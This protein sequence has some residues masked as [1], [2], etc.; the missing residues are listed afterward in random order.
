MVPHFAITGV[1]GFVAPRHLDAIDHVGGLLVA[2]LDPHDAVGILDQYNPNTD[3]F[4]EPERFERHLLKLQ[5]EGNGINWL[6][7]CSPNHLHDIH[8]IMG[9]R[10][11]ANVI[12]EKPLAL[13][14]WNLDAIEKAETA[15][16]RAYTVLQLRLHPELQALKARP[17]TRRH[18]VELIYDTPCGRWYQHSWKADIEKSGGLITN[19]GIHL[20]DLLL[21]L[22]GPVEAVR[23]TKRM[24]DAASGELVLQNADVSWH[25]S[26][27]GPLT[28]RITINNNTSIEF[29]GGFRDLH[30]N[31]Y[32]NTLAGRGFTVA[33]ARPAVE[34]AHRLR[35]H[36]VR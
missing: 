25:L 29:S 26:T 3:F 17:S 15:E 18:A 1:A 28:Q 14:P 24:D 16:H 19:I 11:G 5:R 27:R 34:L 6:S 20:L 33:D 35:Y 21:W 23:V 10:A 7:V 8:T 32:E 31:V 2:A 9:L 4:T 13:S 22:Y 30:K 12:C 36:P